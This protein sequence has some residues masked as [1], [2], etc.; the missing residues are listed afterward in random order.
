MGSR[1]PLGLSLEGP[2]RLELALII[3]DPF[4]RGGTQRADQL[5]LQIG[6]T[7]EEPERFHVGAGEMGAHARP[8]EATLEVSLL[9]GVTQ[10]GHPDVEALRSEP[11]QETSD[12]LRSAHRH[13]GDALRAEVSTVS[14]CQGFDRQSVAD[15]FDEHHGARGGRLRGRTAEP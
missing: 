2:E 5:I 7:H 11:T 12:V 9:A 15:P 6:D 4:D 8:V 1:S 13:H 3:D 14:R 10:T